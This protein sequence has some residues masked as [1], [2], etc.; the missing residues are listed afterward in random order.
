MKEKNGPKKSTKGRPKLDKIRKRSIIVKVGLT[1][2]E[3]DMVEKMRNDYGFT[4]PSEAI[5]HA[6]LMFCQI[7]NNPA[8]G[9][10]HMLAETFRREGDRQGMDQAE[11]DYMTVKMG[12]KRLMN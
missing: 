7:H 3:H 9:I 4:Y 1:S 8:V 11:I 2:S 6:T 5:R 10:Q 12:S